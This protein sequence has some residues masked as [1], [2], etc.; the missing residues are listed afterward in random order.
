M[1]SGSN[2]LSGLV[3]QPV[4]LAVSSTDDDPTLA[5][6]KSMLSNRLVVN[7]EPGSSGHSTLLV[8]RRVSV[9]RKCELVTNRWCST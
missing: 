5:L 3:A 7:L 2:G 8:R 4:V 1:V 9:V 6:L